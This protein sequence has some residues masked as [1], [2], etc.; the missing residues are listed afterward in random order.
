MGCRGLLSRLRDKVAGAMRSSSS[1]TT[2]TTSASL[3]SRYGCGFWSASTRFGPDFGL[4]IV[5][6]WNGLRRHQR[7]DWERPTKSREK[8]VILLP[9]PNPVGSS[10]PPG[11]SMP[12]SPHLFGAPVLALTR[13]T[14]HTA[15]APR[16]WRSW[17]IWC[18]SGPQTREALADSLG[19]SPR[20]SRLA[21]PIL[22]HLR[23]TSRPAQRER[24][25]IDLS[26]PS[27]VT[28]SSFSRQSI[29]RR[30][31]PPPSTPPLPRRFSIRHA[32]CSTSGSPPRDQVAAPV[33]R[34][35]AGRARGDEPVAL[36][37]GG[38]LATAGSRATRLGRRGPPRIELA[39]GRHRGAALARFAEY[40]ELLERRRV[41]PSR[42]LQTS[43]AGRGRPASRETRPISEEWYMHAPA[44]E[45]SLVAGRR[46]GRRWP[47]PGGGSGGARPNRPDRRRAW[48]RKVAPRRRVPP[49]ARRRGRHGAPRRATTG[50]PGFPTSL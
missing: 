14:G 26:G 39:T 48:S 31:A 8:I 23:E 32:P 20:P 16:R 4:D 47:R 27:S 42:V 36:A 50:V 13:A 15:T 1:H 29:R 41:R 7:L 3:P 34:C 21:P 33:H 35:W 5:L 19:E 30:S 2:L 38:E 46:S 18:S 11:T 17:P 40:K 10:C 28:C 24:T 45:G 44:F 37:G 12:V 22:K 9:F 43:C 49:L 6:S 25:L